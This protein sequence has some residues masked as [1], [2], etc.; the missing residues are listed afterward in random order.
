MI[1]IVGFVVKRLN[2]KKNI[3]PSYVFLLSKAQRLSK[4]RKNAE[5]SRVAPSGAKWGGSQ[6]RERDIV[7]ST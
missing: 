2:K 3:S 4:T 5:V 1:K 6:L 7:C